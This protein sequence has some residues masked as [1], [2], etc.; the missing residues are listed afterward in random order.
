MTSRAGLSHDM[1]LQ[2][3]AA[4]PSLSVVVV[5][6]AGSA[7]LGK[8]LQALLFQ[9]NV[10]DLEIIVPCDESVSDLSVL[11]KKFPK[12]RFITT[13]GHRTFAELRALG[14]ANAR[15][16]IIALTEDHCTPDPD[17]CE[18]ILQTHIGSYA[19]AGGAVEKAAPDT[20]LN[21][22]LYLSDYARYMNPRPEGYSSELTDCN[23]SY[24]RSAL[25]AI[26]DVWQLEFHEPAVHGALQASGQSLWF[27]PNII[28]YQQRSVRFGDAVRDRYVFGRLF[29]SGRA[30][31][32]SILPRFFYGMISILLPPLLVGRVA[33]HV[34]RRHRVGIFV[35]SLPALIVLN[36]AWAWG[37]FL[38]YV[39]GRP[40]T[41]LT[42]HAQSAN[43]RSQVSAS[44]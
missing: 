14:V 15:G 39:T 20:A 44:T 18:R 31:A 24:K 42:P 5:T 6:F 16:T 25:N 19:A 22:A 27:S 41:S 8:C 38:G 17:W 21:W 2:T 26:A 32:G 4:G 11:Q 13:G 36:S 29:G 1:K 43:A 23:V 3:A 37:E 7:Y 30:G 9:M 28:V 12:I 33:R 34:F 40:D 10:H 35:R